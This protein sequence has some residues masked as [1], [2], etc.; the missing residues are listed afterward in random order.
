M[1]LIRN[2]TIAM[3]SAMSVA[4]NGDAIDMDDLDELSVQLVY[5]DGTPA[6]VTAVT[7]TL[8]LSTVT[9]PAFADA[10]DRDYIIYK[11]TNGASWAVYLDKTGTSVAPTGALYTAI[12]ASKKSKIDVSALTTNI[13]VA[14]AVRGAFVALTGFTGVCTAA[15]VGD[16][17]ITF[18]SV[19]RA[20]CAA[21]VPK[22]LDDSGAGSI[23]VLH[24][25]T[26]VATS[27]DTTANSITFTAAHL[28]TTGL[29][30]ALT[31]NSGTLPAG[32]TATNYY[33]IKLSSVAISLA[34]SVANALAGTAVD[35]TDYGDATKTM[36]FTPA[37]LGTGVLKLQGS[38]DGTNYADL[39][40]MATSA[41]TAAG[42]SL[43]TLS[44]PCHRWTRV[45][46]TQGT[47]AL[48]VSYTL[49][50]KRETV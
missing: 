38:N 7:G 40:N 14:A 31:I 36:T 10:T 37:A 47:G 26:G 49:C 13:E 28:L 22:N 5:T 15:A 18:T 11:D 4:T 23:T 6:A 45:A 19:A 3:G 34:T 12:A 44:D 30:I 39:A 43:F 42:N 50:G 20:P 21:M 46:L 35:I 2:D 25:T 32:T 41:I 27:V 48:T 29:K 1:Q 33:V 16:G 8:D 24:S 17:T 9:C